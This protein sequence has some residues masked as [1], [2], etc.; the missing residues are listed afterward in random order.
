MDSSQKYASVGNISLVVCTEQ[1]KTTLTS[2]TVY[3][4]QEM[5]CNQV[6]TEFNHLH[7]STHLLAVKH[8]ILVQ[9]N[10]GY[11]TGI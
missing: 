8:N 7:S 2:V 4:Y 1:S 3:T 10:L 9:D 5:Q 11:I 6:N